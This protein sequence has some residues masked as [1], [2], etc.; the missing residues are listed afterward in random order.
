MVQ[1]DLQKQSFLTVAS[2]PVSN[3]VISSTEL[4][5]TPVLEPVI[6]LASSATSTATVTSLETSEV[7][8]VTET[9]ISDQPREAINEIREEKEKDMKASSTSEHPI[10]ESKVVQSKDLSMDGSFHG[11]MPY[12]AT[13]LIV[14]AITAVVILR[15]TRR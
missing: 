3:P 8:Q 4:L 6:Q 11:L 14:S 15:N 13:V 2:T 5:S 7:T 1:Q 10:T 9:Q 12:F